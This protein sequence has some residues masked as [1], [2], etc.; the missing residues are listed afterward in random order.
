MNTDGQLNRLRPAV[1]R[2]ASKVV[3]TSFA[4]A[5]RQQSDVSIICRLIIADRYP[6]SGRVRNFRRIAPYR[7]NRTKCHFNKLLPATDRAILR[8]SV[9]VTCFEFRSDN[10]YCIRA[11]AHRRRSS[12]SASATGTYVRLAG[13]GSSCGQKTSRRQINKPS[14]RFEPSRFSTKKNL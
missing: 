3:Q 11:N 7:R 5:M 10:V 9:F 12:A 4:A 2:T 8:L 1:L 14:V 13:C 6:G